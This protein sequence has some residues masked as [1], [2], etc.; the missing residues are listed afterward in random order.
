MKYVYTWQPN[1]NVGECQNIFSIYCVVS[2]SPLRPSSSLSSSNRKCDYITVHL[3]SHPLVNLSVLSFWSFWK[4]LWI[5]SY[6]L[7]TC[8]WPA[9]TGWNMCHWVTASHWSV[10]LDGIGIWE[11]VDKWPWYVSNSMFFIV[12]FV[13]NFKYDN[14]L[15]SFFLIVPGVPWILMWSLKRFVRII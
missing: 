9:I 15:F 4:I 14:V 3:F 12:G 5:Y 13:Q 10:E 7:P 11:G 1:A 2:S 8:V 6:C